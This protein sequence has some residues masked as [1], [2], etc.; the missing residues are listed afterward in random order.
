MCVCVRIRP[1]SSTQQEHVP[2]YHINGFTA[3]H[4]RLASGVA[5]DGGKRFISRMCATDKRK[6]T[7]M[8]N[9]GD[10]KKKRDEI[11]FFFKKKEV[12]C[13]AA[14]SELRR[15]KQG[16][17]G[18]GSHRGFFFCVCQTRGPCLNKRQAQSLTAA[19]TLFIRRRRAACVVVARLRAP[20]ELPYTQP[21]SGRGRTDGGAIGE[22]N[23]D[24]AGSRGR[25][26]LK[27]PI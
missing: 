19:K 24:G 10:S 7:H 14:Y 27:T 20:V 22:T 9:D 23:P 5:A 1:K 16:A 26:P 17:G 8:K 2:F 25:P 11:F 3:S 12:K 21:A 15:S 13:F 6:T 18:R 4:N